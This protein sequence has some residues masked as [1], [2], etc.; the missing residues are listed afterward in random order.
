[1]SF[2]KVKLPFKKRRL[3]LILPLI[4]FIIDA[5]VDEVRFDLYQGLA[6]TVTGFV[7][8]YNVPFI[9]SAAH[10]KPKYIEDIVLEYELTDDKRQKYK[11]IFEYVIG[12]F[13][14]VLLGGLVYNTLRTNN[15]I[16]GWMN[17]VG[18]TGGILSMYGKFLKF[19]GKAFLSCL[20]RIKKQKETKSTTN[21]T[22]IAMQDIT[23]ISINPETR[24][25]KRA[26][27]Y[28]IKS[29]ITNKSIASR[30]R[31]NT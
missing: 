8:V 19:A 20:D 23:R 16:I 25:N 21:S 3:L 5:T 9:I 10:S 30:D 4:L 13:S 2:P 15:E 11:R 28:L 17:L 26:P 14:S 12:F 31:S 6:T 18:I 24:D 7:I 27:D 1:M 29:Q 22:E